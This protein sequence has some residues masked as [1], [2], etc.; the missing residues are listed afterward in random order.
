MSTTKHRAVRGLSSNRSPRGWLSAVPEI[1]RL[2]TP[3]ALTVLSWQNNRM[4]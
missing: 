1:S 2:R 4:Q 3:I